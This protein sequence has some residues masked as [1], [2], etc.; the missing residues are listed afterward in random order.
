MGLGSIGEWE[1]ALGG[2]PELSLP[3]E[4]SPACIFS[5]ISTISL[6]A[7]LSLARLMTTVS[8][9]SP[10]KLIDRLPS[11]NRWRAM[12]H[13]LPEVNCECM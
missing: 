8:H 10:R 11:S 2:I 9:S 5:N 7:A 6:N 12:L 13:R 4:S 1:K 3:L